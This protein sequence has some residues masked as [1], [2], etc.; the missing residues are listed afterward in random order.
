MSFTVRLAS[1]E[2]FG[3]QA[4]E[5]LLAAAAR[6]GVGLPC[7]CRAG[8]CGTCRVQ[9]LEGRVT[10]EEP[11]LALSPE[12]MA[13]GFALACQGR[14]AS[15]VLLRV[16]SAVLAPPARL[17]ATV[18][19][20]APLGPD[21]FR[22]RLRAE[23][24]LAYLPGQ[25]VKL[26]LPGGATRNFSMA[27]AP[28]GGALEFHIRRIPGGRFTDGALQALHPGEPVELELPHGAFFLRE[29]D[30]R[31]LLMAATGTGLAPIRAI[32]EQLLGLPERPP[33]ALYWG[34]RTLPDL[35]LHE[36]LLDWARQH[37]SFRYEPVLSRAPAGWRGRRGYVQQAACEDFEDLSGHAV[38]LCGSPAMI[39][40]ARRAFV[41]RGACVEH[42]YA[43]SF[44]FQ[45]EEELT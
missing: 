4:G 13:A 26:R 25:Y 14:A 2:A 17:T 39:A 23:A 22:L 15:D 40:S 33:V 3:A 11:P 45:R 43:D 10:Y 9:L 21:V 31:P 29:S 7:D 16:D 28:D 27:S 1:G 34:G 42:I 6:A 20:V 30:A 19:A 24:P 18:A 5:T 37:A 8:G 41:A 36:A 38:Y 32:V 12:E 44:V 35:Y